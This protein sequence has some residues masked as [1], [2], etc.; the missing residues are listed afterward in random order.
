MQHCWATAQG[1]AVVR[2]PATQVPPL[3]PPLQHSRPPPQLCP[4]G[5]QVVA[6][7]LPPAQLP[8]QHSAPPPQL[9]P[10]ALQPVLAPQL[11]PL[12]PPE[13]HSAPPAQLA[14]SALQ[15]GAA[16]LPSSQLPLQ[17]DEP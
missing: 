13:Q 16:H 14:P 6:A 15:L 10:S 3:Q 17:H 9:S 1:C 4:W 8:L 12:Q 5:L 2:Q 7:Q 11:P